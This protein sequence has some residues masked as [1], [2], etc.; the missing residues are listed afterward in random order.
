MKFLFEVVVSL[1]VLIQFSYA[2]AVYQVRVNY[3]ET[4]SQ[5]CRRDRYGRLYCVIVNK[6]ITHYGSGVAIKSREKSQ[7]TIFT[8]RHNIAKGY[9]SIAVGIKRQW[10]PA[11]YVSSLSGKGEDVAI[12][13]L[14]Y[15]GKLDT[16]SFASKDS[17]VG[18]KVWI[19]GFGGGRYKVTS[20]FV[21]STSWEE[22]ACFE[23]GKGIINGDSGGAVIN[24]DGNLVGLATHSRA[25]GVPSSLHV[26]ASVM[27]MLIV[28]GNEDIPTTIPEVVT[29]STSKIKKEV[30]E[31]KKLVA[32]Q[33][34]IILDLTNAVGK[35][36]VSLKKTQIQTTLIRKALEDNV[37]L[38]N[39][40]ARL[41]E[42]VSRLESAPRVSISGLE[43][44]ILELQR[45][46]VDLRETPIGIKV[47]NTSTGEQVDYEEYRLGDTI[48]LERSVI[49]T[50]R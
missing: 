15:S 44:S 11:T 42:K 26:K 37:D 38:P 43:K 7:Y 32:S 45:S 31:L 2:D 30:E 12:L 8:A 50:K 16:I 36:A 18:D 29:E 13:R 23:V 25:D 3:G 33:N 48:V 24:K 27:K 47:I 1:V 14:N 49:S 35:N 41:S 10:V 9:K 4:R 22:G 34:K 28:R 6:E 5:E 20:G 21:V 39:L 40:V 46:I 19:A 17:E